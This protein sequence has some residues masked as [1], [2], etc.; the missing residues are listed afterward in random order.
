MSTFLK[1]KNAIEITNAKHPDQ[2][3]KR[4]LRLMM[5]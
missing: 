5:L 4:Q 2:L 3:D 1:L